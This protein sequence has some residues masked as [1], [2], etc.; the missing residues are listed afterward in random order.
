[1]A[2]IENISVRDKGIG[3]V[4][5]RVSNTKEYEICVKRH[6][7][8]GIY[9]QF[10]SGDLLDSRGNRVL[11]GNR[12]VAADEPKDEIVLSPGYTGDWKINYNGL[13]GS[14]DGLQPGYKFRAIVPV[15]K[16][17]GIYYGNFKPD[18]II[19]SEFVEID[20]YV[21]IK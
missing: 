21:M 12:G 3:I 6:I 5:I 14:G 16:C 4:T 18:L 2:K 7:I 1:M 17:K 15:R 11:Y 9:S 13:Y 10:T 20:R 8:R 19:S